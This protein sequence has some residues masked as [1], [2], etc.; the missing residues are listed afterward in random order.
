MLLIANELNCVP[1]VALIAALTQERHLLRRV[2]SSQTEH[3]RELLLGNEAESDFFIL[4][5]A[6]LYAQDNGPDQARRL[7]IRYAVSQQVS[8]LYRQF[9]D[10]AAA[11]GLETG[12]RVDNF[13]AE[14]LGKCMLV[15]FSDHLAKRVDAGTLR[16][17]LVHA[18]HGALARD[19][20]V[21]KSPLVVAAEIREIQGRDDELL[22]LLSQGTA[23]RE[24]WLRELFPDDFQE[25]ETSF[26]DPAL[27]RVVARTDLVFRDLTLHSSRSE[28]VPGAAVSKV[29]AEEILA[30]R[31]TLSNWTH[32]VEQWIVRV[33]CLAEW[34]PELHLTRIGPED[35]RSLVAQICSGAVGYREIKDRPVWPV[36]RGW[37]SGSQQRA[38]DRFAPERIELPG[39]RRP[40][41]Q[42]AEQ[43]PPVLSARIQDLYG[44]EG[45]L[46]ICAGRVTVL[47]HVLAPN[48]R[49]VQIT[50]DLTNFWKA[51]YPAIKQ[52]LRRKY[53]RHEWR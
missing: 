15:G 32:D 24:E 3:D 42:Y 10:I 1:T 48:H 34:M 51:T 12:P 13:N 33:N 29:L 38:V 11:E 19:S 35:R 43:Q 52:E 49:P 25:T 23:V 20:V 17:D 16:C 6:W 4:I 31:C 8:H 9:M 26:F 36:V 22:V 5:R 28:P 14:A 46:R 47:I 27:R 7:G 39:G 50:Q 37:L 45:S 21:Q 18:R 41:L 53:P 40:K 44:V 30:G 2:D